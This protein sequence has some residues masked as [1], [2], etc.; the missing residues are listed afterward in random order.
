MKCCCCSKSL[1]LLGCF[2]GLC[3]LTARD[4]SSREKEGRQESKKEGR[5]EG[6]KEIEL[7]LFLVII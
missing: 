3:G 4:A 2:Q 5:K 7:E 6:K 1:T